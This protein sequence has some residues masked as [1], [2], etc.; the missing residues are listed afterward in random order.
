MQDLALNPPSFHAGCDS[1]INAVSVFDVATLLAY[2]MWAP[3]VFA[4]GAWG[5]VQE[6]A[7]RPLFP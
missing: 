3:G 4:G 1:G 7:P 6:S 2:S 5:T